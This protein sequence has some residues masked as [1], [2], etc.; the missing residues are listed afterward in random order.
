M[1]SWWEKW[2]LWSQ[3]KKE[4]EEEKKKKKEEDEEEEENDRLRKLIEEAVASAVAAA[5]VD[6]AAE[7][8]AKAVAEVEKRRGEEGRRGGERGRGGR[9]REFRRVLLICFRLHLTFPP[10]LTLILF[11]RATILH[12]PAVWPGVVLL[13]CGIQSTMRTE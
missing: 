3:E 12:L 10:Y 9:W 8:A 1:E 4:K 13:K 11:L 5:V 2:D 7:A 6:V